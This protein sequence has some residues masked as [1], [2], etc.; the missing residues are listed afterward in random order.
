MVKI[1]NDTWPVN[2]IFEKDGE[3]VYE[4]GE[5][6]AFANEGECTDAVQIWYDSGS[7]DTDWLAIEQYSGWPILGMDEAAKKVWDEDPEKIKELMPDPSMLSDIRYVIR[8]EH[9]WDELENFEHKQSKNQSKIDTISGKLVFVAPSCDDVEGTTKKIKD[10]GAKI[11]D[12]WTAKCDV[13][14]VKYI[15]LNQG[16]VDAANSGTFIIEE[17]TIDGFIERWS[18]DR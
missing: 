6:Q 15:D 3:L 10:A 8:P 18:N 4:E 11:S 9:V 1:T 17:R 13:L 7:C 16:L 2:F 14:I 12:Y 5:G